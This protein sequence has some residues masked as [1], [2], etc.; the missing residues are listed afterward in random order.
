MVTILDKDIGLAVKAYVRAPGPL[1]MIRSRQVCVGRYVNAHGLRT[2][3]TILEA[4][5]FDIDATTQCHSPA[6]E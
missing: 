1:S 6:R 5:G 3:E 2:S 4:E